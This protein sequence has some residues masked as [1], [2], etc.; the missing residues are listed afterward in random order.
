MDRGKGKLKQRVQVKDESKKESKSSTSYPTTTDAHSGSPQIS[1]S[2]TRQLSPEQENYHSSGARPKTSGGSEQAKQTDDSLHIYTVSSVEGKI[3]TSGKK[4]QL[5]VNHFPMK[6]S[7]PGG[8]IYH[9]DVKFIFKDKKE[10]KKSD[11]KLLL[12]AIQ[13]LKEK[14]P[15]IFHHAVVFDGFKNVYTCK[16]LDFSSDEFQRDVEIKENVAYLMVPEV[17]V[18]LKFKRHLNVNSAVAEYC[19]SGKTE[20]KPRDAIQALNIVLNMKPQL[21][22]ETFGL[23]HFDPNPRNGTSIDIGGGTSLW[24]GTFTSVRLGWEPRLN[25]DVANKAGC[26]ESSVIEFMEKVLKSNR[27]Y[28][29]SHILL[30]NKSHSDTVDDKIK[31]LRIHYSR[32]NGYKRNYRVNKMMPAANKLKVKLDSGE[33]CTIE[34]YFKDK[35]KYQLK[36]P[37][38]PCIHVGKRDDEIYLPIELCRMKKQ[39]LPLSKSL[40]DNQSQRMIKEAAKLPKERRETIQRNL[41]NLSNHYESDPYANDFGIKVSGEMAKVVGRVLEPPAL[42]YE[43]VN[44]F[45]KI[46]YGKWQVGRRYDEVSN[47]LRFLIPASLKYWGVLDLSDLSLKVKKQFVNRVLSECKMRG[48]SVDDPIYESADIRHASQVRENF[49][50]LYHDIKRKKEDKIGKKENGCKLIILVINPSKDP[51]KN[52]LKYLGDLELRVP[53]Q[54][55]LKSTVTGR[56]NKGPNDQVLHDI[57]LKI[58]HKL[59]GVNHALSKQPFILDEAVMVMGADVTHP[60]PDDVSKKPSI[61][62]VVGSTDLHYSQYNGEI[63]L[64][65][66][67]EENSKTE[68]KSKG[69]WRVVEEIKQMENIAYSL[70]SKFYQE[71]QQHPEQII[72]YRDG[73]SEG[74]FQAILNHELSAIR[75][76]CA[77]LKGG[78]E[79]KVTFI[80]AQKRHKTRVF[81]ENPNDGIGKTKNIPPGTVV[82]REITTLSEIDFFLASHEGIQVIIFFL[83]LLRS[84]HLC[85]IKM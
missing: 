18:I 66:R 10:V 50:K 73:V 76:A 48:L 80:I 6:I 43:N 75:R 29:K 83:L 42:K 31:D 62:A 64:Q 46:K 1:A 71:R 26:D 72:Y 17:K 45:R 9:Y 16:K 32:P 2:E 3:G 5:R 60:A 35:Y 49:K 8:V 56:D 82:D 70:L 78:C 30:S 37:N 77:K 65:G 12:E 67:V 85:S 38:Y 81:V 52:E 47:V 51:I 25:V 53:T 40:D 20:T 33:E 36:F 44:E 57:C 24:L 61:A 19:R 22:Y 54:F 13:R 39:F 11:R 27:G 63:R 59:G 55:I 79:P 28:H 74:E 58:N 69:K 7:V 84:S 41:R 34:K 4:I 21:H 14:C 23:N 15:K 68:K